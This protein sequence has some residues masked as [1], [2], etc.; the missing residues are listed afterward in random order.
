MQCCVG[1]DP[2]L[3][4]G[5]PT[6]MQPRFC[7]DR[8]VITETG[9]HVAIRNP[10]LYAERNYEHSHINTYFRSASGGVWESSGGNKYVPNKKHE[11]NNDRVW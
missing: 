6:N 11:L 2:V 1:C 4:L 7:Y 8:L 5:I 3:A 10:H 9:L